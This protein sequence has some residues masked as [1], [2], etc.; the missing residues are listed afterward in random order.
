MRLLVNICLAAACCLSLAAA[1]A[2]DGAGDSNNTGV[3]APAPID[4]AFLD[5]ARQ[6]WSRLRA[7]YA[8]GYAAKV[9]IEVPISKHTAQSEIF[10]Q[11]VYQLSRSRDGNHESPNSIEGVNRRYSF[12]LEL[13][14]DSGKFSARSVKIK[15]RTDPEGVIEPVGAVGSFFDGV[16]LL[17]DPIERLVQDPS[18]KITKAADLNDPESGQKIKEIEF[19]ADYL[20]LSQ[21]HERVFR[22]RIQLLPDLY[23]QIKEYELYLNS[24]TIESERFVDTGNVSY[25]TVDSL[26]FPD[27]VEYRMSF[28]DEP[29][30]PLVIFHFHLYDIR[31][32]EPPKKECFLKYYGLKEPPRFTPKE[33]IRFAAVL[34][35][36]VLLGAGMFL[37]YRKW[38][39]EG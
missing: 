7:A 5:T 6:A 35:A 2:D 33:L 37:K 23:W 3:D 13:D 31:R 27:K 16:Q 18:F 32:Q 34:A 26:P 28:A 19:E 8:Q 12:F 22:G 1:Y 24:T 9:D 21:E 39:A 14:D 17:E 4:T 30:H 20:V 25:Q 29:D 10:Y 36:F 11:G 38:N 15:E